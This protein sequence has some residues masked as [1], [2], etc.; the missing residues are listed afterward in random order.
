M[1]ETEGPTEF[2]KKNT[3]TKTP[4]NDGRKFE[5][6]FESSDF[7]GEPVTTITEDVTLYGKFTY[8]T[9]QIDLTQDTAN[10]FATTSST[11][12]TTATVEDGKLKVSLSA[13]ERALTSQTYGTQTWFPTYLLAVDGS[14]LK[15]TNGNRAIVEVKYK[16]VSA[17][18]ND[19]WGAQIGIGNFNG[20]N[21]SNIYVRTSKKHTTEDAGKEFTLTSIFD[22][23]NYYATKIAFAGGGTIEISSIVVHELPAQ[24]I[25]EYAAVKYVESDEETTEFALKNV[26][27][28]SPKKN[29]DNF[30]AWNTSSDFTGTAVTTITDDATLYAKPIIVKNVIDL[31]QDTAKAFATTSSTTGTTAT[32][33]DGKLKVAISA[34]EKQLAGSS[35]GTVT[36]FPNYMLTE[37]GSV[38][39]IANG[40][41]A[42]VEVKYKVAEAN[43][44]A[45]WG[46]Q[47]GI[48][49]FRTTSTGSNI[50]V[51]NSI[52]H[53]ANDKGKEFTLT[54][55]FVA[56][57]KYATKIAF[58]GGGLIEISSIV[59]YELDS[60]Y[61]DNYAVVSY[62]EDNDTT[63]I[64]A[65]KKSSV[66]APV[67]DPENFAGWYSSSDFSGDAVTAIAEDITLYAKRI[68]VKYN[69]DL[70]QDVTNLFANT[71]SELTKDTT[72]T[73]EDG[74]LKVHVS[75]YERQLSAYSESNRWYP[76]YL[77]AVNDS[78]LKLTNGNKA[79]VEVKYKVTGTPNATHGTQ[80]G[81]GS[82]QTAS[83]STNVYLKT[84]KKHTVGD[85][86]KEFT[87]TSTFTADT[88]YAT[89][90]AFSG[91]G[92]IE[93]SSIVV[94]Q[95]D[96]Q[97]I[98]EYAAV[99]CVDGDNS[100][101][102]FV[103][104]DTALTVKLPNTL[105][106]NFGGWYNGEE[107]VTTISEDVTLTAKWHE[108]FDANM[109]AL[110]DVCDLVHIKKT[111]VG[112]NSDSLCDVDRDKV[113]SDTDLVAVRKKLLD[114]EYVTIG[115]TDI[116]NYGLE[117]GAL[118]SFMTTNSTEL[119][120]DSINESF[121]VDLNESAENS[122]VVGI[123]SL[124]ENVKTTAMENL[125]GVKGDVYGL[126]DY[127]IFIYENDLYIE[128]GSDYATAFAVNTFKDLITENKFFPVGLEIVGKYYGE[129]NLF[130]GYSYVWGDEFNG[131]K[132]DTNKWTVNTGETP[133]PYYEKTN[134]Y[135]LSSVLNG[136]YGG[137]WI[138][139]D[140]NPNM[141]E[142]VITL[143]NEEG[144]NYY[145]QDGLLVM[146]TKKTSDGYSA[147]KI[148][149]K[150]SF[151]YGIMTARVKLATKN[152]ACSTLWS[153]TED[154]GGA[155]VNE[156][157][158]VEN[159][160]SDQIVPNLHT[161]E[162][163]TDHTNH[164]GDIDKQDTIT[165]EGESLSDSF[166]E[167]SLY[168][169][170]EKIVFYFDG[171]PYLEQDIGSDKEKWEAFHKSTYM[172]M[173]V[174]APEGY[175]STASG[176]QNPG[177]YLGNLIDTFS[178]D[179]AVDYIRVFQK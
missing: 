82:C 41:K 48:G 44:N 13:Y 179:F 19:T 102:D 71:T 158:F 172:I 33:E 110:T 166:H 29:T 101:T 114:V 167:I 124:A 130:D 133:G 103:K 96:S 105:G 91:G 38:I 174:S 97:Y 6:W 151:T 87:L 92:D 20:N 164:K 10:L 50:N 121:G 4:D 173:G 108:R 152:A 154:D 170:E 42:I 137:P 120:V 119:F 37:N 27:P 70:T 109:D 139:P 143:L 32:V 39:K 74:K 148:N 115:G 162:N 106:Y 45:D 18:S 136:T 31:T 141:Q 35:F 116:S 85:Q 125:T 107:K 88:K 176:G 63:T 142:G 26:A 53:V 147:T 79:I 61:I 161:W 127:K 21:G 77:L 8:K 122:I 46:A 84:Y 12:G 55:T 126:D 76:N 15:L 54:S 112:L 138:D 60:Q 140:G 175:Y 135:Y 117:K 144:N 40:D 58:S 36:Y 90:I 25:D 62:V 149:A 100:I 169:D 11:T 30:A 95:L 9:T 93:I 22:V 123:S 17:N 83:A 56:D 156:M 89:Q 104:K 47:I 69:I 14:T 73:A 81:I 118:T 72:I 34:Y 111:C 23:D 159:F 65:E 94:Y 68:L 49:S 7:S 57:E 145:L 3:A 99:K 153:R 160:G 150:Q 64:F 66:K 163:Y 146:N 132:L 43:A 2:T 131:D 52:K 16:V 168:W 28:R 113:I 134:S 24:F 67:K 80:I 98:S 78:V 128:A 75:A 5:G 51:R 177:D 129:N 157:D 59:L 86:G 1:D 178:E 165:L 155:S 171:V